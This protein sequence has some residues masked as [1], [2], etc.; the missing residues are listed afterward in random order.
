MC[1]YACIFD[2]P[3]NVERIGTDI[4]E[5]LHHKDVAERRLWFN[6]SVTS[7]EYADTPLCDTLLVTDIVHHII[8]YNRDD[9]GMPVENRNFDVQYPLIFSTIDS[10]YQGSFS[11]FCVLPIDFLFRLWYN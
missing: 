10:C 8:Q 9:D 11:I 7:L 5:Y 4:R 6:T 1:P 3:G 2:L